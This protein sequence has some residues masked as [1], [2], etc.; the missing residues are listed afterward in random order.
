M[1]FTAF[2]RASSPATEKEEFLKAVVAHTMKAADCLF[3]QYKLTK[4]TPVPASL[5]T[6]NLSTAIDA[7]ALEASLLNA[8]HPTVSTPSIETHPLLIPPTK[9]SSFSGLLDADWF[10]EPF[11]TVNH[12]SSAAPL[13]D[14]YA[15]SFSSPVPHS[16]PLQRASY[17]LST[18]LP[19]TSQTSTPV[20]SYVAPA[21]DFAVLQPLPQPVYSLPTL[22]NAESAFHCFSSKSRNAASLPH[23][24][25]ASSREGTPVKCQGKRTRLNPAQR[26]FMTG[27]FRENNTPNTEVLKAVAERVG[28]SLRHCQYW[29]Q[30]AAQRRRRNS[31]ITLDG[32]DD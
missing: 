14:S 12:A 28:T 2:S 7:R 11:S 22:H 4:A 17:D 3:E 9:P 20:L 29:F 25:P 8:L 6:P 24:T 30:K 32:F 19:I 31:D 13:Q 18:M 10:E 16:I 21:F 5:P 26:E 23:H 27:V 15:S 1:D